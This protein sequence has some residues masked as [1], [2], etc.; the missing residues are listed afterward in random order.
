MITE[1]KVNDYT[2]FCTIYVR[3]DVNDIAK[4]SEF[5][6]ALNIENLK[7]KKDESTIQQ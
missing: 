6:A 1:M 4:I 3:G 5:V 2:S 7:A